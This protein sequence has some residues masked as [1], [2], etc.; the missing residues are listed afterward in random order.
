MRGLLL[1]AIA[2]AGFGV[3]APAALAQG[4]PPPTSPIPK[5]T[6]QPAPQIVP[7]V[8]APP[9]TAPAPSEEE[10]QVEITAVKVDGSTRYTQDQLQA[11]FAPLLHTNRPLSEITDA[12]R[13]LE[14]DYHKDG[15]FL[16]RVRGTITSSAEGSVLEVRVLE[17][18]IGSV[19]L[20][21]DAGPAGSLIYGYL[22]HLTEFRPLDA[23]TLERYVLLAKNVSGIDVVPILR[24]LKDEPG[25]V[26]LVAKLDRKPIDANISDDNRGPD[27]LGPNEMLVNV[28]ANAFTS[29]GDRTTLTIFNTPFDNEEIFGQV[30]ES[31]FVGTEGLEFNSY[32]GYGVLEPGSI[33]RPAGYKSRLLLTGIEAQYPFIRSRDLSLWLIGNF[34]ISNTIVDEQD[35]TPNVPHRVSEDDLRILRFGT[36]SDFQDTL[37]GATM[38]G[39]NTA[40]LKV[41][42]GIPGL[43]DGTRASTPF[44][45]RPKEQPSFQKLTAKFI[46]T[47]ELYSWPVTRLSLITG[48]EGQWTDDILPPTEKFFL[49]GIDFGRGFYNGEATGDRGIAGKIQPQIDDQFTTDLFGDTR[50]IGMAY[51]LYYD[52]GQAWD[53]PATGNPSHHVESMGLGVQAAVTEHVS[54]QVEGVDRFTRRPTGLDTNREQE[55]QVFFGIVGRY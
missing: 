20:D 5:V 18:Y 42:I 14:I 6:P 30:T 2:A 10:Q 43:F 22:Q 3:L 49:G 40:E 41:H 29:F 38:P 45:A 52:I 7:P 23:A 34:D 55:Y 28:S 19:K 1:A 54:L 17:G 50:L 48:A 35:F 13:Q 16:T 46:R 21:G 32:F 25:A 24:P 27:T 8:A 15:F 53:M 4:V 26:E 37:L 47:Q 9:E 44:P 39:A 31:F 51:Y 11:R 33:L 12:V 36:R